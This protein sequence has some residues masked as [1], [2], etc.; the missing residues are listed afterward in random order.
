MTIFLKKKNTH[1]KKITTML[2]LSSKVILIL[3]LT[4]LGLN[5]QINFQ[6]YNGKISAGKPHL[7]LFTAGWCGACKEMK[8]TTLQHKEL[9]NYVNEQFNA[10]VVD[11]DKDK[12]SIS[13]KYEVSGLPTFVFVSEKG[14]LLYKGVGFVDT[15]EFLKK[16]QFAIKKAE[17]KL[18]DID[19]LHECMESGPST[20]CDELL[21][22]YLSSNSWSKSEDAAMV[23]LDLAYNSNKTAL[24]HVLENRDGYA[25]VISKE[26]F[27]S[28]MELIAF[29]ETKP[30]L[31]K[32][33][34]K[35]SE[36]DWKKVEQTLKK[37]LSNDYSILNLNE[38]KSLYYF[39]LPNWSKFISITEESV[40]FEAQNKNG[41]EKG[42]FLYD[43]AIEIIEVMDNFEQKFTDNEETLNAKLL[44]KLL[45]EAEK[46]MQN[47]D[48]N[49]YKEL[50]YAAET[51]QLKEE[52]F[53]YRVY[54]KMVAGESASE[55]KKTVLQE[56][57]EEKDED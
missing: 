54:K 12:S 41:E 22:K 25:K 31:I 55:A 48:M 52:D 38:I 8:K 11:V 40:N 9:G 53:Y 39:E 2:N 23:V 14:E 36:P 43:K 21:K 50:S 24:N 3:F 34:E 45:L 4:Q 47:P 1:L 30:M 42:K 16:S 46:L 13:S 10:Y 15:E 32:C 20:S 7:I 18:T 29:E 27:I 5:A 56:I 57:E 35:K 28:A 33:M 49:L 26:M 19:R 44:Y 6:T 17:G 37:Y 51:L